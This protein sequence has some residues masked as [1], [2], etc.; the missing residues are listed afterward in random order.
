MYATPLQRNRTWFT[1][2]RAPDRRLQVTWHDEQRTTVLS[3]WHGNTCAAT[4]QLPVEDS[5]LLITQLAT[6][7]TNAASY[8]PS[9]PTPEPLTTRIRRRLRRGS[10]NPMTDNPIARIV[11]DSLDR[12]WDPLAQRVEGFPDDEYFW[13]P[14]PGCWT[15][16]LHADG[17]CDADWQEPEPDPAPVTTIAWRCWHIAV[18]CLDSYSSRAFDASGTGLNETAWV[19][20]GA[21]AAELL[22]RA[23]ATFRAGVA[24]WGD[25]D[26]LTPLGPRFPMNA[27]RTYLGLTLHA[28]REIIHHGA[29]I[30][31]LRDLYRTRLPPVANDT[32]VHR[33]S[34]RNADSIRP[35]TSLR[36]SSRTTTTV[37]SRAG[38]LRSAIL[39]LCGQRHAPSCSQ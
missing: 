39:L 20:R 9:T 5:A 11:L 15:V 17:T 2:R 30:A 29:E 16:R 1:D 7:I 21:E 31:L 25:D 24:A 38:V 37:R 35:N 34:A 32:T 19:G 14:N 23:W 18:D 27:E 36:S 22:D 4:F 10:P 8:A 26:L 12:A 3:I 28:E 33:S 13:E 6:G